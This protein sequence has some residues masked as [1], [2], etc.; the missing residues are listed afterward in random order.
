[1]LVPT[2]YLTA[3]VWENLLV[4]QPAVTRYVL[5]GALLIAVMT[6]RPQGPVRD[7]EGGDRL[8]ATPLLELEGVS[9]AFGGLQVISDLDLHVD[10]HEIVSVIGPN[11]AAR[12]R[13]ST[14][15]PASTPRGGRDPLRGRVDRRP[16]PNRSPARASPATFQTLACS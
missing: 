16:A 12:R 6:I 13:S 5:F 7:G 14:S 1:V 15:S 3:F 8:M 9:K 2:L 11:G 4:Q 10:E